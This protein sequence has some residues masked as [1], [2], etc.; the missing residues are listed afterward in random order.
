MLH[1]QGILMVLKLYTLFKLY[2][3]A[4]KKLRLEL[5]RVES[6]EWETPA[7]HLQKVFLPVG[8]AVGHAEDAL[9][10]DRESG[11]Q[12]EAVDE[13]R[14]GQVVVRGG[15]VRNASGRILGFVSFF[16]VNFT[17]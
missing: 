16:V 2:Q 5:I 6:L 15:V 4:L 17:G 8:G 14:I 9:L 11:V 10:V 7:N 1:A 13:E 12:A 3:G